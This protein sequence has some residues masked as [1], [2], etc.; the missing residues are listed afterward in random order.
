MAE[1]WLAEGFHKMSHKLDWNMPA[2]GL[3]V[4]RQVCAERG[5][6]VDEVLSDQTGS[7]IVSAAR[8]EA[9]RRIRHNVCGFRQ[10]PSFTLIGRWFRRHHSSVIAACREP[11]QPD[12][13]RF[14]G[15]VIEK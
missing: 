3:S 13:L 9:M 8:L 2:K 4:V 14:V 6:S 11:Y 10:A 5:V 7:R 15:D 12:L 1:I